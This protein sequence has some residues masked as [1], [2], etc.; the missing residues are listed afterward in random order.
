MNRRML[1]LIASIPFALSIGTSANANTVFCVNSFASLQAALTTSQADGDDDYIYVT[2]GTYA[3]STGLTFASNEGHNLLLVGGFDP[4]CND[5][6]AGETIL[7]GQHAVRPLYVGMGSG[8]LLI[9]RLTFAA[10]F[11]SNTGGGLIAANN[12]GNVAVMYSQFAGNRSAGIAGALYA[13]SASGTVFLFGNL[14]YA[15]RGDQAG[16]FVA[17]QDVGEGYVANNTLV[18]NTSDN[19]AVPGGLVAIGNAHFRIS[20]NILWNNAQSNGSDFGTQSAHSRRSNDIGVV[21]PGSTPDVLLGEQSVEPQFVTCGVFCIDFDLAR[22]SPMVDAGSD[23]AVAELGSN[24]VDLAFRPRT[25]GPHVDIGAYENDTIF[26]DGFD[27]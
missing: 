13:T 5:P 10:G 17:S 19:P 11:S 3:L 25:I 24:F 22:T 23:A 15:N 4:G 7:D 6:H 2:A 1:R 20:N 8:N 12:A 16:G 21:A 27:P 18:V 9:Q 26:D 14:A